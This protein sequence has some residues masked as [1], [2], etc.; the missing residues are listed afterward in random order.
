M[1][2]ANLTVNIDL[3]EEACTETAAAL[4]S[5][6]AALTGKPEQ[7]VMASV[8]CNPTLVFGGSGKPAA[9]LDLRGLGIEQSDTK[10]LSAGL[11]D[12]VDST[13][14]ISAGRFYLVFTNVDRPMWGFNASTF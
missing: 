3:D 5:K 11:S 1:P 7:Y 13:L 2:Y 6:V 14:G 10:D 12:F 8:S 4:S 9:F